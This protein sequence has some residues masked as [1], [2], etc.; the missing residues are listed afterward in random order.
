MIKA[1]TNSQEIWTISLTHLS[2]YSRQSI[3][4]PMVMTNSS[5]QGRR[6]RYHESGGQISRRIKVG[7]HLAYGWGKSLPIQSIW[8][9]NQRI[10]P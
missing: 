1:G 10:S 8:L 9:N 3:I 5:S 7:G 6:V 2:H 4:N